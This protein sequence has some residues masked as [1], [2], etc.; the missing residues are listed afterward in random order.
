MIS[1]AMLSLESRGSVLPVET[2]FLPVETALT[3]RQR[4]EYREIVAACARVFGLSHGPCE[5][6]P[7]DADEFLP[8]QALGGETC[9]VTET[10]VVPVQYVTTRNRNILETVASPI[11]N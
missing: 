3:R 2:A 9:L 10:R 7:G 1:L 11:G 6:R 5:C 8:V 4:K